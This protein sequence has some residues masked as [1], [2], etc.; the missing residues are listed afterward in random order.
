[1]TSNFMEQKLLEL[2]KEFNKNRIN[3]N[4]TKWETIKFFQSIFAG[5]I[6]A[7][8]GVCVVSIYGTTW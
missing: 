7:F 1:M 6:A 4:V 2:F 8:I 3:Y 5:L